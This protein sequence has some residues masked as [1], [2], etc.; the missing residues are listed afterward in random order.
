MKAAKKKRGGGVKIQV[1]SI[2]ILLNI[3][4]AWHLKIWKKEKNED[5]KLNLIWF[6]IT[7]TFNEI[8]LMFIEFVYIQ[9]LGPCKVFSML[10][11]GA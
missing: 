7:K 11:P 1:K 4:N 5:F 10:I 3:D 8:K 6:S 2:D 9:M